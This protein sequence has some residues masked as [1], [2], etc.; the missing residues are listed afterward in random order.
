MVRYFSIEINMQ[1]KSNEHTKEMINSASTLLTNAEVL[2]INKFF[3][4]YLMLESL[5]EQ[6]KSLTSS[7]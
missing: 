2:K 5:R 7:S 1:Y 3:G 6:L 4:G